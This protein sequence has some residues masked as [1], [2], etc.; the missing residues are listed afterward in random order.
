MPRA[1]RYMPLTQDVVTET[2]KGHDRNRV[3]RNVTSDRRDAGVTRREG[4]LN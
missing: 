2:K 4:I 3:L 1:I